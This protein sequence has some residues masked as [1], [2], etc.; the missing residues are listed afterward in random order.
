MMSL[1]FTYDVMPHL[2]DIISNIMGYIMA[3]ILIHRL[4]PGWCC[5]L[6]RLQNQC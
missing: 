6:F 5:H 3:Y 1:Q 4:N 2:T